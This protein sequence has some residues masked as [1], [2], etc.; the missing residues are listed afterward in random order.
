MKS[1]NGH[2][3]IT[4]LGVTLW[5][6]PKKGTP[7]Y[8]KLTTLNSS[9]NTLFPGQAPRF[10]PHV[11]ITTNIDIDLEDKEKTREEVDKILS[12]SAVALRSLP[13][14]HEKLVTLGKLNSQRYRFKKLYLEVDRDPN[15]VSF[16]RIIRELFVA[17]PQCKEKQ[18]QQLNPQLYTVDS[19]GV[20]VKRSLSKK[21]KRNSSETSS[22]KP[23]DL[24]LA[25]QEAA[26]MAAQWSVEE[27]QPHVS[28]VYS[29]LHPIDNALWRT[30]KTRIQ[31]FLN[32][33]SCDKLRDHG[34]GWD[35]GVLKLVYCEGDVGDWVVL[36]SVDIH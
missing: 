27:F 9:L 16:A 30:I 22:L 7:L 36:G 10:E 1:E 3:I 4:G 21:L 2:S 29:S 25:Q 33:P 13:Q 5:L 8:D 14:N 34:F 20:A 23:I 19:H 15:L 28:L 6:C 26:E 24:Q 31:D 18:N 32:I 12:A 11:T 35:G 17:L